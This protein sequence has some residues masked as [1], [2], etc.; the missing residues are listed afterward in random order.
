MPVHPRRTE[1]VFLRQVE[2]K[3]WGGECWRGASRKAVFKAVHYRND[4]LK[5]R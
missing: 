4:T 1:K 5:D 3:E 2:G